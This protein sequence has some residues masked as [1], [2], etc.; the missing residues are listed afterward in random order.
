MINKRHQEYF[1]QR[2]AAEQANEEAKTALC[3]EIETISLDDMKS[4]ADWNAATDR[5][6]VLQKKWKEYGFAS[7]KANASLYNRFRK[8]CDAFFEAK[9]AY[10]QHTKDELNENLAKKT[11]LCEKAEALKATDDVKKATEEVM[12]L[13]AEWKSIGS[14]PRKQSD[15]LWQRFTTACNYFFDE[16][17]RQSKERHREEVENLEKK[18]A[19]IASLKALPLDGDR[20]EVMPRVKELQAEWQTIGFVPFIHH[21]HQ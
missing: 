11:A 15:A 5:I 18:R 19:V 3:E 14:V 20:A 8:A 6:I 9:T 17:K 1:E 7:R 4:F 21:R 12:K 10:F 16:R 2:K 13:Q